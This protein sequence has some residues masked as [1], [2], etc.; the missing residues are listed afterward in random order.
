MLEKREIGGKSFIL[1]P[2]EKWDEIWEV[3]NKINEIGE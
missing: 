2:E 3:L 1:I